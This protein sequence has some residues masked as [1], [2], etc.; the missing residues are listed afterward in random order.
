[1]SANLNWTQHCA[2]DGA[3]IKHHHDWPWKISLSAYFLSNFS[4][5]INFFLWS[6]SAIGSMPRRVRFSLWQISSSQGEH[7]DMIEMNDNAASQWGGPLTPFVGKLYVSVGTPECVPV[8]SSVMVLTFPWG[9]SPCREEM[10]VNGDGEGGVKWQMKC[11]DFKW[12]IG[13]KLRS[14]G[15]EGTFRVHGVQRGLEIQK[16]CRY[17]T[18]IIMFL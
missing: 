10:E 2:P 4:G 14:R 17:G 13:S 1:M 5:V 18:T 11:P 9:E 15:A 16:D 6:P 7:S 3:L 12:G 8:M